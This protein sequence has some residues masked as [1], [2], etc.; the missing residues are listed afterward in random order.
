[1]VHTFFESLFLPENLPL[2]FV[3]L[4]CA[5]F[6]IFSLLEHFFTAHSF[7]RYAVLF[8]DLLTM[9]FYIVLIFPIA[10]LISNFFGIQGTFFAPL[11]SLPLFMR[12]IFYY[13]VGD[14]IHYWAH[15]LMHQPFLWRIHKWHHSPTHVSW[16]GGFRATVLDTVL[17]N[18]GFVFAWPILGDVSYNLKLILLV[19]GL[20][21]NDWMHLNVYFRVRF[22]EH[23]VIM[24]RYHH[25]HHSSN[26]EHYIK[27]LAALFPIWDKLFGT[28]VDPDDIH[29]KLTFGINEKV[30]TARLVAGI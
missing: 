8:S 2:L 29:E 7:E 13:I 4:F 18:F 30:P 9:F 1:M 16:A 10:Q 12:V 17:L 24:P 22:L 20:L 28:Y 15:R 19:F 14:F 3:L 25:I 11:S 26:K 27:N 6:F 5:R 21:I 23:V